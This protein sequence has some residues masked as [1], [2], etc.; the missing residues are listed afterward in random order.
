MQSRDTLSVKWPQSPA[1]LR[2]DV[3][4]RTESRHKLGKI[5]AVRHNVRDSAGSGTLG[6][7]GAM[8][9]LEGNGAVVSRLTGALVRAL[10]IAVLVVAPSLLVP[11]LSADAQQ[12]V[13]LV[14][15]F[16][17]LL[18]YVEYMAK[19]PG[20]IEFR[21]APP[22]N[23][24]RVLI[25]A[26]TV[27]SLAMIE[28]GRDD[29]SAIS[30]LVEAL[31]LLVGQAMDFP[32]SPVRLATQALQPGATE[33]DVATIRTAAGI[34]YLVSLLGLCLFWVA[35]RAWPMAGRSFNVWVN[36]PTFDPTS[37]SDIV[38]RLDRDA[39]INLALGFILPFLAPALAR[40]TMGG[41]DPATLA[42]PHTVIWVM[43]AWS[44]LPASLFMR[45]MA[46]QRIAQ[47][48]LEKR[49]QTRDADSAGYAT[50]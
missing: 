25:L 27:L 8:D 24:I 34:A 1:Y 3:V 44:F 38:Q 17:A 18:T 14:A 30:Q 12:T 36:L 10:L 42:A 41:I 43:A 31:G 37:S 45:G 32:Y 2:T 33:A 28:K 49:R 23:R 26:A 16:A 22:F 40:L 11:G 5:E 13:A 29:P 9:G 47:M 15:L 21:D 35:L 39:R 6:K 46:M 19:A 20:L 4:T 7:P 50:A 48:I